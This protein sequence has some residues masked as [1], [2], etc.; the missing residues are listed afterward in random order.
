MISKADYIKEYI[1]G[2][3]FY[4]LGKVYK[5]IHVKGQ[6]DI[7]L[8]E[9]LEI[10]DCDREQKRKLL[11]KWYKS[12]A[13][14]IYE[15][16]TNSYAKSM[17]LYPSQIKISIANKRWGSCSGKNNIN[18]SW[19]LIMA[20]IEVLDY[21]IIHELAHIKYKNHSKDFWNLVAVYDKKYR[22]HRKWLRENGYKLVV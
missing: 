1:D 17:Q 15:E 3:S 16:R 7:A 19:R 8:S 10:P 11:F 13:A 21:V 9:K 20:P 4:Y 18:L 22:Q 14:I 2:E 6:R 5:L 12:R